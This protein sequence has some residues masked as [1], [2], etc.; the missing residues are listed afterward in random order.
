MFSKEPIQSPPGKSGIVRQN[1]TKGPTLNVATPYRMASLRPFPLDLI[2]GG[3]FCQ[4]HLVFAFVKVLL[5][6]SE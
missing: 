6:G 3:F 2:I 4:L 5:D 1:F